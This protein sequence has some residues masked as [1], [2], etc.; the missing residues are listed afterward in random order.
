MPKIQKSFELSVT[1]EQFLQACSLL[2][3][4]EVE[5]LLDSHIRRAEEKKLREAYSEGESSGD[6]FRQAI[7]KAIPFD[8]ETQKLLEGNYT[9]Q[10]E[11]YHP[12]G[13]TT[14][15]GLIIE[16]FKKLDTPIDRGFL[17]PHIYEGT[18]KGYRDESNS[19]GTDLYLTWDQFGRCANWKRED[20]FIKDLN[21]Q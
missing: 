1:P 10:I 11:P 5:L 19:A 17:E 4:Q 9:L 16:N 7:R 2:E 18:I 20:L 13:I 6:K 12:I 14:K 15:S 8:T 3:L 21:L